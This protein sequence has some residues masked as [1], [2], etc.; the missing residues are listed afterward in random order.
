MDLK[1]GYPFSLIKNG[2]PFSYPKLLTNRKTDVVIIGGGISGALTAYHLAEKGIACIVVDARS[3]GLGSTCASTSLL[4]YEID[5]PLHEL[6]E[7]VGYKNA[8][9][10]YQLCRDSLFKLKTIGNKIGYNGIDMCKSLY[11]AAYKKDAGFLEKEYTIRKQEGFKVHYLDEASLLRQTN[12]KAPAAILSE[13]GAHTDAYL[14]TH[15]LHQYTIKK[16][17]EVYDRSCVEK[18]ESKKEG[19]T[20]HLDNKITIQAKTLVNAR[21]YE[22]TNFI[23]KPI[24]QLKSTYAFI[25]E[26]FEKP[27]QPWKGDLL[28]WST[29]DPYLYMRTTADNR[30]LIGGRDED[31]YSPRKRDELLPKKTKQLEKDFAKLFPP[32]KMKAEFSW[33]GTFGSTKDGLPYIG[34]ATSDSN[35]YYALGFGGN[36]ITFSV[37]AGELI[38]DVLAGKKNKDIEIFSFNR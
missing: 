28:L 20:I 6:T 21:G 13:E 38:A 22:G 35:I 32:C 14:L 4:Q 10:A 25:T 3:I 37:I 23:K 8:V 27:Q 9:K 17:I 11:Y 2:L 5:T 16:G 19:I 1:S 7:K 18:I 29:A 34:K 33:T 15:Y 12:V 31:F 26:S 30:I 24:V 36:G